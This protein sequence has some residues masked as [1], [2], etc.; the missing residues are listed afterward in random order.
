[1]YLGLGQLVPASTAPSSRHPLDVRS[2]TGPDL[3]GGSHR[4]AVPL[5]RPRRPGGALAGRLPL[6]PHGP[7]PGALVA[8]P[9]DS[10]GLY[11]EPLRP[12]KARTTLAPRRGTDA[13][14]PP[15]TPSAAGCAGAAAAAAAASTAD[16]PRGARPRARAGTRPRTLRRH[17][18]R[19]PS[20][21]RT[22]P[23]TSPPRGARGLVEVAVQTPDGPRP[24]AA[25]LAR[26][27]A[28]RGGVARGTRKGRCRRRAVRR[29]DHG[30]EGDCQRLR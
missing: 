18:G 16:G 5:F 3:G 30:Q 9:S 4:G 27:K 10:L 26:A 6:D 1:M 2:D 22:E 15:A 20:R 17:G 29:S 25:A 21:A 23:R 19:P 28:M 13:A 11:K 7:F 8:L 24:P 14:R 12:S